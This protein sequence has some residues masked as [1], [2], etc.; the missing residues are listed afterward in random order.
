M[1]STQYLHQL[2]KHS[3]LQELTQATST[4]MIATLAD[5]LLYHVVPGTVMSTDLSEGTTTVSA[6]NG[7]DL[8]IQVTSAE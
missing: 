5:I 8:T 4:L 2:T 1:T 3:L 7:D 6:A